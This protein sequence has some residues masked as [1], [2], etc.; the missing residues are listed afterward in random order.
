MILKAEHVS[1]TIKNAQILKDINLELSGGTVYGFTLYGLMAP[2]PPV[3][4]PPRQRAQRQRQDHAF[5][6]AVWADAL[7]GRHS[8]V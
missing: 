5:S 1:K 8:H 7:D 3:R 6:S 2:P 4:S